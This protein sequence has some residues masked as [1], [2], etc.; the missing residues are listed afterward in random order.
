[1]TMT[2]QHSLSALV[3]FVLLLPAC[4][5]A[6]SERV[7]P[8]QVE[9]PPVESELS[10]I[11]LT[12]E[13]VER[14][15]IETTPIELREIS[16]AKVYG[17]DVMAPPGRSLTI[18]APME[19]VV[20]GSP[21]APGTLVEGR[22]EL[23]RFLPL[24]P[25]RDPLR[26]E[27]E[28]AERLELARSE[29]QRAEQLLEARAASERRYEDAKAAL[30]VAEATY[31]SVRAQLD[32][33]RDSGLEPSAE[34]E[35]YAVSSP[36]GGRIT[37]AYVAEGQAVS[38]SGPLFDVFAEDPLWIRVA[39]YTGDLSDVDR[40]AQAVVSLLGSSPPEQGIRVDPV[41][42]PPPIADPVAVTVDVFYL[43]PNAER[44]FQP[45]QRV[46]VSL[47]LHGA[48]QGLVVPYG[49]ILYDIDGGTWVYEAPSPGVFVRRRVEL[50][51]VVEDL[52]VLRRAPPAG[53]AIVTVGA[54]ELFGT[55]F[56]V[57]H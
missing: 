34:R 9:N 20:I 10:R 29:L 37:K 14:L 38:A 53:T 17:G 31:R 25:E 3:P 8:A 49:A 15:G 33:L 24:S 36:V 1:M 40:Q 6:P 47:P 18:S 35:G 11:T 2:R 50:A 22:R 45:G 57:G 26:L 4:G 12:P 7:A 5:E 52:A 13:A 51:R 55:E 48:D 41:R 28:A 56:G 23:F 16:R 42:T 30:A 27:T 43:L 44:H 39:V 46:S 54:A 21:P 19:G 32:N